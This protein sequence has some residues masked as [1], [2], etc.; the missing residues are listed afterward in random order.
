M[1]IKYWKILNKK[2]NDSYDLINRIKINR[3][4]INIEDDENLLLFEENPP[5]KDMDLAVERI[6][7]ALYN[8]EKIAIYGDYDCDGI[9]STALLYSY[10]ENEGGDIIYYIPE[11]ESEGYGLNKEAIDILKE[12]DVN[13]IIT[14]DNGISALDEIDYAQNLGIDVV[15]TDHHRPREVLPNAVAVVDPHR[16]D[17]PSNLKYLCGAGVVFMLLAALEGGDY[18]LILNLY[19]DI[20]A[21][22]TVGDSVELV[23]INRLIVKYGLEKINSGDRVGI[24]ALLE[25]SG[26]K[27]GASSESISFKIA[28]R[29]NAA[30]R[31][32]DVEVAL[33]LL[34]TEDYEQA[35]SLASKL[36]EYNNE[37]KELEKHILSDIR[38]I[39]LNDKKII[40][41][42][43]IIIKGENWHN[44]VV[45]IVC[46]KVSE[47][48]GKPCILFSDD[49][50][51]ARGSGRSIDGFNMIE[52]ISAC[53]EHLTRFGGHPMA[54]GMTLES[55][56]FDEF[57]AQFEEYAKKTCYIMPTA[58]LNIDFEVSPSDMTTEQIKQ[59]DIFAP[60]GVGNEF[61]VFCMKDVE[62][63]GIVSMGMGKHIKI[64]VKKNEEYFYVL[65]FGITPEKFEYDIGDKVDI[66]FTA[67][68]NDYMGKETVSL[69]LKDIRFSHIDQNDV[70]KGKKIYELFINNED[71]AP[72]KNE[73]IPDRNDGAVIYR[74]LKTNG[75]FTRN[76]DI[77]YVKS[78][79]N[80]GY[81]KY[82]ILLMVME[83]L[84]LITTDNS[85][86]IV[87]V[88]EKKDFCNSEI[89]KRLSGV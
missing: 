75:R 79:V 57:K 6:R 60:Y 67:D 49:G 66:A 24:N 48:Y 85:I 42:R 7:K 13:L 72:Y 44:G 84:G 41:D 29:I 21:I 58:I 69:K 37:R 87:K 14:V 73:I 74:W 63:D 80:M 78:G 56:N 51:E 10:L 12:N 43:V 70:C 15:V 25:T 16:V 40:S 61:P 20:A 26:I 45:G 36:N 3:K 17:C 38:K 47:K 64:K 27:D 39:I 65:G 88:K 50:K 52:A 83:E 46:S 2:E 81:C 82:C 23:G 8:E 9:T 11:R 54:A 33:V 30:G 18:E 4:N 86:D 32:G 55:E 71:V 35:F 1:N 5:M 19:S 62:I 31:V 77:M 34:L 28:P 89:L 68:I 76:S 53:S 22:G 59:L